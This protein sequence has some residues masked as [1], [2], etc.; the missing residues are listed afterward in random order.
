MIYKVYD[1][2]DNFTYLADIVQNLILD[3]NFK[4]QDEQNFSHSS[5]IDFFMYTPLEMTSFVKNIFTQIPV[6]DI[7][8]RIQKDGSVFKPVDGFVDDLISWVKFAGWEKLSLLTLGNI[9][10]PYLVYYRKTVE[11]LERI[12]VCIEFHHIDPQNV[13]NE[14]EYIKHLSGSSPQ[15]SVVLFGTAVNQNTVLTKIM[16]EFR[17]LPMFPIINTAFWPGTIWVEGKW[18]PTADSLTIQNHLLQKYNYHRIGI[19]RLEG[20]FPAIK[21]D[22]LADYLK[23]EA[24]ENTAIYRNQI[25]QLSFWGTEEKIMVLKE[26]RRL[27]DQVPNIASYYLVKEGKTLKVQIHDSIFFPVG[28]R[29]RFTDGGVSLF[30]E[31]LTHYAKNQFVNLATI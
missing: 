23:T 25:I 11:A 22:V 14:T 17:K 28:E 12:K 10:F 15:S 4:I 18:L 5:I 9:D 29:P 3:E 20:D 31:F 30:G 26:K 19:S 8:H 16:K 6:Y 21:Y 13:N 2:C 24:A 27:K 1:V 7:D